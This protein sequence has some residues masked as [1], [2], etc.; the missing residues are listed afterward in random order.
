MTDPVLP[1]PSLSL[2]WSR[3]LARKL[4][5]KLHQRILLPQIVS[6]SPGGN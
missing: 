1:H 4:T 3:S 6:A 2:I 5:F